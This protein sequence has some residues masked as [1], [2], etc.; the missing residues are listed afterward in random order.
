MILVEFQNMQNRLLILQQ[1]CINLKIVLSH[2]FFYK[3][4]EILIVKIKTSPTETTDKSMYE[5]INVSQPTGVVN[6]AKT[7]IMTLQLRTFIKDPQ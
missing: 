1:I 5:M 3:V 7:S 2:R 4:T 6:V